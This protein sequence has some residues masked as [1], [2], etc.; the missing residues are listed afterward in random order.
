MGCMGAWVAGTGSVM[1]CVYG[2]SGVEAG[3]RP[4]DGGRKLG[5][6]RRKHEGSSIGMKLVSSHGKGTGSKT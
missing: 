6:G 5:V 3:R 1:E 4:C 2:I